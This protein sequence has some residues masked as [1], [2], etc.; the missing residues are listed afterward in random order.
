MQPLECQCC[1][2]RGGRGREGEGDVGRGAV[3]AGRAHRGKPPDVVP[4]GLSIPWLADPGW[5]ISPPLSPHPEN[6][7]ASCPDFPV[8]SVLRTA[9]NKGHGNVLQT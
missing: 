6:G 4:L 7:A 2:P 8:G 1:Q 9:E 5:A 3:A